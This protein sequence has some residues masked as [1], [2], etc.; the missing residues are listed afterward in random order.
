MH[1]SQREKQDS[2]RHVA[3]VAF[4]T[5]ALGSQAGQGSST[6]GKEHCPF[7][8][9]TPAIYGRSSKL[10]GVGK[11]C[12]AGGHGGGPAK[13]GVA[14]LHAQRRLPQLQGSRQAGWGM[15]KARRMQTKCTAGPNR[16]PPRIKSAAHLLHELLLGRAQQVC[17]PADAVLPAEATVRHERRGHEHLGAGGMRQRHCLNNC[18]HRVW[19]PLQCM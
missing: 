7:M 4:S 11:V 3:R 5:E 10:T 12:G 1:E 8:S 9:N 17:Q 15:S 13:R 6:A 18:V 19:L 14:L 2:R 16:T